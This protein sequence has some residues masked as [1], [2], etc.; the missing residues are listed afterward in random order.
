M[1]HGVFFTSDKIK[2]DG[3]ED[4]QIVLFD[5]REAAEDFVF[6]VLVKNGLIETVDGEPLKDNGPDFFDSKSEAITYA[7]D[8]LGGLEFLHVYKVIDRRS[9]PVGDLTDNN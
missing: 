8:S 5:S 2:I 7:Q 3:V 9:V 6:D 4:L 1:K